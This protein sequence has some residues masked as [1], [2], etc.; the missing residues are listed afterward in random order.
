MFDTSRIPTGPF[1]TWLWW[2]LI[3][4]VVALLG[5]LQALETAVEGAWPHQRRDN[6]YVPGA[7]GVKGSWALAA[8]L[9]IPGGVALIGIICIIIWRDISYPD[10]FALGAWL[11]A[12]GWILFMIFGLNVAGLGRI[13][14]TLGMLGP[15]AIGFILIAADLILLVTLREIM[16]PWAEVREGIESGIETLLPFLKS[17]S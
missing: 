11:L 8:I 16:P 7:K 13:L 14:G 9:L 6:E 1:D 3:L 15:L 17:D 4:V 2:L 12:L 10:G 5:S